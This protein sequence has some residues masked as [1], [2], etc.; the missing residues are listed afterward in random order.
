MGLT[1]S[2]EKTKV[3]HITEGFDF[4]GYRIIREVWGKGKDGPKGTYT[5]KCHQKIPHK[6]RGILAP[7]TTNESINAKIHAHQTDS[8]GDGANTTDV[9]VVQHEFSEN[10]A[11]N[12]IWEMAHWLGRKYKTSMP[13]IM[14]RFRKW[15]TT[16]GTKTITGTANRVQSQEDYWQN[17]A[18]P[19]HRK[20][21][22][23]TR[24]TL[25]RMK[26]SGPE[27]KTGKDGET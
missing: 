27:T 12:S 3:T 16:F 23:H 5:R 22:N 11:T 20:R 18:Q 1:L 4:L 24:K 15:K 13:E 2:E 9:Q 21:G 6:V 25:L 10:S 7:G 26:T 17:L 19:L 8:P 14:Q